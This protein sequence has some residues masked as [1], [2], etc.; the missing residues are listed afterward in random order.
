MCNLQQIRMKLFSDTHLWYLSLSPTTGSSHWNPLVT[1]N[2]ETYHW[3]IDSPLLL[4]LDT[5]PSCS[6]MTSFVCI[7]WPRHFLLALT[8][9][10][11]CWHSFLN[12]SNATRHSHPPMTRYWLTTDSHADYHHH[13]HLFLSATCFSVPPSNLKLALITTLTFNT[14]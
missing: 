12:F 7:H 5:L 6:S 1:L 14:Y 3:L 4:I 10:T 9:Y 2:I 13:F 11:H 8:A